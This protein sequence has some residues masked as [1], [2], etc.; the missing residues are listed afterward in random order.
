MVRWRDI[1]LCCPHLSAAS[2]IHPSLLRCRGALPEMLVWLWVTNPSLPGSHSPLQPHHLSLL[3]LHPK[4]QACAISSLSAPDAAHTALS[5][6][7]A[8]TWVPFLQQL[9]P[10]LAP[11]RLGSALIL[12]ASCASLCH[13]TI[14]WSLSCLSPPSHWELLQADP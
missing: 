2:P 8:L 9:L 3:N 10:P 12:T 4:A 11:P 6:C 5:P 7:K 14:L 1:F 13:N